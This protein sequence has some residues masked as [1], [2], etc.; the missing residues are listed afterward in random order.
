VPAPPVSAS[1]RLGA[2]DA[3]VFPQGIR[4]GVAGIGGR[5]SKEV[6]ARSAPK[7]LAEAERVGDFVDDRVFD[8][9]IADLGGI[10]DRLAEIRQAP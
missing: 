5:P 8:A 10:D 9:R 4:A 3:V 6:E 2:E 1:G 7:P